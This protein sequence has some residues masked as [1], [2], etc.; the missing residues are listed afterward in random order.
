[1][2]RLFSE[3]IMHLSRGELQ[4]RIGAYDWTTGAGGPTTRGSSRRLPRCSPPLRSRGAIL[5]GAPEE[6]VQ[7]FHTFG[8]CLGMAFQIVDDIL[9]FQGTESEVGKPVGAD[10][11]QGV[12][13]LPALLLQERYPG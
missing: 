12:L 11:A 6:T 4:E 1:M 5:S 13:T 10:L 3:T 2:I 7:R 9:D 8:H